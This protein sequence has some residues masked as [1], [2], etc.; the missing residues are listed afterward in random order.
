MNQHKVITPA[1]VSYGKD[2]YAWSKDQAARLRA[3]RPAQVD[4]ENLAEVIES[5]G[6]S[7]RRSVQSDLKVILVHLIKWRYQPQKRKSGWRASIREHRDRIERI[8]EDSPSLGRV[9][10]Q[11]LAG[12]YRKA[13]LEAIEDTGLPKGRVPESCPFSIEQVLDPSYWPRSERLP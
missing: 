7:D 13:R 1:T 2:F 12:E 5:V 8:L 9:P 11:S 3:L 4:W 6:R 10:V